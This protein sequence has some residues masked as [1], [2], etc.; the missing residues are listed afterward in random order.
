M[1]KHPHKLDNPV[2]NALQETH[3]SF[4]I[5]YGDLACYDPAFC[6]FGG[7]DNGTQFSLQIAKYAALN[8]TFFIVGAR[9]PLPEGLTL[10]QELVCLQMIL[11]EL[12][13]IRIPEQIRPL[14]GVYD[15]ELFELVSLVQPGYFRKKTAELGQYFGIFQDGKLVAATGERMQMHDFVELS[16][17]VTHPGYTGRGYARQLIAHTARRILAQGRQP[18]LHVA[19][20]NERAIGVYRQMGFQERARISF[21]QF[22][23]KD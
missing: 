17:I 14:N 23:Q 7:Y 10:V 8:P 4:A 11:E 22:H 2:W 20:S 9:P 15:A 18:F 19:E 3:R 1:E 13:D 21:W 5:E 16:A 12:P 6:P